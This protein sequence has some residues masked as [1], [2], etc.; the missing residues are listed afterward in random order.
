M[1]KDDSIL[2]PVVSAVQRAW[3]HRKGNEIQA[4]VLDTLEALW[5][6]EP[7]PI[8]IA[9]NK[10]K[11]QHHFVFHLPP[12]VSYRDLESKKHYFGDVVSGCVEIEKRGKAVV[13]TVL[14]EPI[15]TVLKFEMTDLKGA[16]LPAYFGQSATGPV[17]RDLADSPFL[18]VAGMPG[19]GKSNSIHVLVCNLLL[20]REI[21]A[22]IVDMKRLEFTYLKK[23]ALV[24]TDIPQARDVLTAI[25]KEIDKRLDVL[26]KAGCV[27]I[28]EYVGHMPF[29]LLVIDELAEM[30]DEVCQTL[31]NRALRLG[32][33]AGFAAILSTQRP[34]SDMWPGW[35]SSRALIN[36][37]LV[38]RMRDAVNSRMLL[39]ND[40]A[41]MLAEVK[42]RAI[43]QWERQLEVQVPYLPVSDARALLSGKQGLIWKNEQSPKRLLPR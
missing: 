39:D 18:M 32:R 36:A 35:T 27:K 13:L 41:A 25:N 15:P 11:S 29:M 43:Y 5:P 2:T 30:Q 20:T 40:A 3:R 42:G 33:A 16:Y 9:H 6:K 17:I 26:E 8:V 14:S 34:S 10:N 23:H 37:S 24:V 12:G 7:H 28:Q 21:Y 1:K 19:W 4:G 38:F 22:V 31:I